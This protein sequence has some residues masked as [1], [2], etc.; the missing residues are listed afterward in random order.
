[1]G[2]SQHN[3]ITNKKGSGRKGSRDERKQNR[4]DKKITGSEGDKKSEK[5][6]SEEIRNIGG[7]G[8]LGVG[9][10]VKDGT[11]LNSTPLLQLN[12]MRPALVG[13]L[14]K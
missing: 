8:G 11:G 12:P 4:G 6:R 5:D 1:M 7:F 10:E 9:S 3:R 14:I 13:K 2:L